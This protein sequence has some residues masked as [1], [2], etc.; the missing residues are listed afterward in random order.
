MYRPDFFHNIR[1]LKKNPL[2]HKQFSCTAFYV[3]PAEWKWMTCPFLLPPPPPPNS[4]FAFVWSLS[5]SWNVFLCRK[6]PPDSPLVHIKSKWKK[7]GL[8]GGR[9]GEWRER[10]FF[11]GIDDRVLFFFLPPTLYLL[12]CDLY[13]IHG[14]SFYAERTPP[15]PNSPLV[16]IKSKWKK[17]GL[18]GGRKGEWRD[19]VFFCGIDDRDI[20]ISVWIKSGTKKSG[21][22]MLF[23]WMYIVFFYFL[24]FHLDFY[25]LINFRSSGKWIFET[26]MHSNSWSHALNHL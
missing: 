9:K 13:Q 4:V 22:F 1:W 25:L 5:N 18:S 20:Y 24:P 7:N 14:K 19:R 23:F 10:V 2:S 15:P 11:C 16:H 8:S 6:N 26:L 17:N 21:I 12:L 3:S